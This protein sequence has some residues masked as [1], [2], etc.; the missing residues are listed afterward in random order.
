MSVK[1]PFEDLSKYT[2]IFTTE[3]I[4]TANLSNAQVHIL[5]HSVI[6]N[7][8]FNTTAF[9]SDLKLSIVSTMPDKKYHQNY[10]KHYC[11]QL[12]WCL[13]KRL[14]YKLAHHSL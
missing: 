2:V 4:A 7:F 13:N 14:M 12:L 1:K 5:F 9:F 6:M 10:Y 11:K 3:N 8:N